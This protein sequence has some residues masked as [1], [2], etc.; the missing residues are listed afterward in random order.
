LQAPEIRERFIT[1]GL[2]PAVLTLDEFAEFLRRQ[3]DRYASI[4]KQANVKAD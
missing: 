3:N 2:E 4:V 1:L